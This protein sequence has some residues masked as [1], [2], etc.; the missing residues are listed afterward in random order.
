MSDWID[1]EGTKKMPIGHWIVLM[2][3]GKYG[4]CQIAQGSNC[5]IGII[6]GHFYFDMAPVIAYMPMPEYIPKGGGN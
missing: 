2:E 4:V 1:V 3:D 6:N 5:T